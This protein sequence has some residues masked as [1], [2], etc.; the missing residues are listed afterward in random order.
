MSLSSLPIVIISAILDWIPK[1]SIDEC[2][3]KQTCFRL[4]WVLIHHMGRQR[5]LIDLHLMFNHDLSIVADRLPRITI[6]SVRRD[7]RMMSLKNGNIKSHKWIRASN[8]DEAERDVTFDEVVTP[9]QYGHLECLKY[10]L[11][12]FKGSL[13]RNRYSQIESSVRLWSHG[14]YRL[15]SFYGC[16]C[17]IRI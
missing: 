16:R 5:P 8:E 3:L 15:Q 1:Y 11:D 17:N 7:L 4:K 13:S 12:L 6:Q 14:H 9:I 2:L 10:M